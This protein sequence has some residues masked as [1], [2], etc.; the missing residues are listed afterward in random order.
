MGCSDLL[1]YQV[2]G[3]AGAFLYAESTA[4]AVVIV[5]AIAVTICNL[6]DR[7]VRADAEAVVALE[8]IPA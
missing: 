4:L 7:V 2:D 6:T 8:A 5:K 1:R 3:A